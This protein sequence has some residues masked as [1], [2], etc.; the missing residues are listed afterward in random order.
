MSDLIN[1]GK[2]DKGILYRVE[3]YYLNVLSI[4]KDK[5]AWKLKS[6]KEPYKEYVISKLL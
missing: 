6:V 1:A 4:K 3:I 2:D 5:V